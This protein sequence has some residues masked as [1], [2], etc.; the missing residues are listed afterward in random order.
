M[1]FDLVSDVHMEHWDNNYDLLKDK[2]SNTLIVAGDVSDNPDLT[3]EWLSIVSK[4]YEKVLFIEGNHEH[5][6]T[7]FY[8]NDVNKQI[9]SLV[10]SISNL[11]YLPNKPYVKD[12]VAILGTNGWWDYRI[13][14]PYV[15]RQLSI[16]HFSNFRTPE[17]AL[18]ILNQSAKEYSKMLTWLNTYQYD[19]DVHSIVCITH[20][21]PVK[22]A[23]S[24]AVYPP[25]QNAVGC[26]GNS[27]ME[28]LPRYHNKIKHWCF[29]HN[30]DQQ[31]FVQNTVVYH[32]NPRGRPEDFNRESYKPKFIQVK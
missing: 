10:S 21:L 28:D 20:T 27:M 4:E 11:H 32:S 25:I 13:G 5:Q 7:G 18:N 15:D 3:Y 30:H 26:Y 31:E 9:E 24:W 17:I 14:E 22:R 2:L 1:N 29:G 12:G 16:D 23:I 6:G 19:N 8:I